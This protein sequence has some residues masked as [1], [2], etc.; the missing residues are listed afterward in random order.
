M[1]DDPEECPSFLEPVR[2]PFA[3]TMAQ[4]RAAVAALG[5]GPATPCIGTTVVTGEAPGSSTRLVGAGLSDRL[6]A[7][8]QPVESVD[9]GSRD[10]A[11]ERNRRAADK[12]QLDRRRR[13]GDTPA[14]DDDNGDDN[15]PPPPPQCHPLLASVVLLPRSSLMPTSKT[16]WCRA[17]SGLVECRPRNLSVA[18]SSPSRHMS[19]VTPRRPPAPLSCELAPTSATPPSLGCHV[20]AGCSA[21][22]LQALRTRCFCQHRPGAWTVTMCSL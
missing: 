19:F 6:A 10:L 1:D 11:E 3:G 13:G 7:L 20:A 15:F 18:A 14:A 21:L 2:F 4:A 22:A 17:C 12:R 5:A 8:P 9:K 16:H